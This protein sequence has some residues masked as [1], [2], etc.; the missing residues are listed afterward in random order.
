MLH[1][2]LGPSMC[3]LVDGLALG[4]RG[5]GGDVSLVDIFVLPMGLQPP[6]APSFFSNTSMGILVLS[7]MAGCEHLPLYLSSTG[8]ASQETAILGFC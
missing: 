7:P 8:R 2:T 3:T 5:G 6:S 4:A 1:M